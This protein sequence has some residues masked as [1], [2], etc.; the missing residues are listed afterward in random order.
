MARTQG[1]RAFETTYGTPPVRGFTRMPFASTTLGAEQ[2]PLKAELQGYPFFPA[3]KRVWTDA[4][5]RR[6]GHWLTGRPGPVSRAALAR[7]WWTTAAPSR[8][9][10]PKKSPRCRRGR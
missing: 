7:P 5:N 3:L 6:L 4:P 8:R 10:S 1:A 2:P 9:A